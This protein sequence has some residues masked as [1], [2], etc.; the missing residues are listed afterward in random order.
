MGT[1]RAGECREEGYITSKGRS[2]AQ[3]LFPI[4][5]FKITFLLCFAHRTE[6]GV[7]I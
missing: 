5:Y 6:E 4:K 7:H 2:A 3:G 1:L